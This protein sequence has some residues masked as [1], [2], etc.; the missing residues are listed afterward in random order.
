MTTDV[1][2]EVPSVVIPDVTKEL[3]HK[4]LI[5]EKIIHILLHYP[6]LSPSMLGI[7]VQLPAEMWKPIFQELLK[8]G[9]VKQD[10]VVNESPTGRHQ[11]LTKISLARI[12]AIDIVD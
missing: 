12:G 3:D 2:V 5:R 9:T 1:E 10:F 8:E 6:I 11:T 7:S 4:K